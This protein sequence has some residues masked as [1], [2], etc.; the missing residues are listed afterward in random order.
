[1]PRT[2]VGGSVEG[3]MAGGPVT[4]SPSGSWEDILRNVRMSVE[5]WI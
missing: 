3:S 5:Q 4:M 2:R 1:V